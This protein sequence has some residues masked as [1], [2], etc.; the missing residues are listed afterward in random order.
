MNP[1]A[2]NVYVTVEGNLTYVV[3]VGEPDA[4]TGVALFRTDNRLMADM[5]R[6]EVRDIIQAYIDAASSTAY[7]EAL[8]AVDMI[9][10]RWAHTNETS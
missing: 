10:D 5:V 9:A 8:A 4:T 3:N 7:A 1:P 6:A 2:P